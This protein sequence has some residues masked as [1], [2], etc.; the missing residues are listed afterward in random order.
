MSKGWPRR[1]ILRAFFWRCF[2][3]NEV[4]K[5]TTFSSSMLYVGSYRRHTGLTVNSSNKSGQG[6]RTSILRVLRLRW[7]TSRFPP[8]C[9]A[10]APFTAP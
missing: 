6:M 4:R 5:R 10:N 3:M 8:H 2:L 7:R 1:A 9:E